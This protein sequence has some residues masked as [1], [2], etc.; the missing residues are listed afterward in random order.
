MSQPTRIL[1][2]LIAGL[3]LGAVLAAWAPGAAT[4]AADFAQPIGQAWLNGLQ[5]TIVPL[6]VALLRRVDGNVSKAA[7]LLGIHRT[8]L[9]R[10]LAFHELDADPD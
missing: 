8:Q 9:R 2:S 4:T 10:L 6:V 3:I 5:M 1:L 7:R